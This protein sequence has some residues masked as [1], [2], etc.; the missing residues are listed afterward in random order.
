MFPANFSGE[1][2]SVSQDDGTRR[3]GFSIPNYETDGVISGDAYSIQYKNGDN[4]TASVK[5]VRDGSVSDTWGFAYLVSNWVKDSEDNPDFG[6]IANVG[7][8]AKAQVVENKE[9]TDKYYNINGPFNSYDENHPLTEDGELWL[10]EKPADEIKNVITKATLSG[11]PTITPKCVSLGYPSTWNDK[12]VDDENANWEDSDTTYLTY[13]K[14]VPSKIQGAKELEK[15][16]FVFRIFIDTDKMLVLDKSRC[17]IFNR[18]QLDKPVV[19]IVDQK[20]AQWAPVENAKTYK[21]YL[22]GTYIGEVDVQ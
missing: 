15:Y 21:I 3:R 8:Y 17:Y 4:E 6:D 2:F 9:V 11:G 14:Q 5:I 10:D 16:R 18:V 12:G 7:D 19:E 13:Q 22:A 20:V 1:F